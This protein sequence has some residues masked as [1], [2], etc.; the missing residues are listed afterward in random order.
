MVESML[1]ISHLKDISIDFIF[2]ND[3]RRTEQGV[4]ESRK[5]TREEYQK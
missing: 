2:P 5:P 4:G 1:D 3:L